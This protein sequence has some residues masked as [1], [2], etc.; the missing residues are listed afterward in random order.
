MIAPVSSYWWSFSTSAE[1]I[2]SI[3]YSCG[4]RA[5]LTQRRQYS[6]VRRR[7]LSAVSSRPDSSGS[8][9]VSTRC[10]AVVSSIGRCSLTEVSGKFVVSRIGQGAPWNWMWLLALQESS[11]CR[12]SSQV[13]SQRTVTSGSPRKGRKMRTNIV[14]L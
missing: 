12:P 10:R 2:D 8:P 5:L 7:K 9:N 6:A 14:G 11:C 4:I 13:G 1:R 3:W